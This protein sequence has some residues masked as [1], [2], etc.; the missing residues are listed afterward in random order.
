LDLNMGGLTP[1]ANVSTQGGAPTHLGFINNGTALGAA[2]FVGGS[3]FVVNLD[4]TGQFSPRS[5]LVTFQGSGPVLPN[6]QSSHAH[7]I[8]PF[9]DEVLVADLGSD[10]VWRLVQQGSSWTIKGSIDQAPGSGPR[11]L[12]VAN[13]SVF[14]IHEFGNTVTQHTIAP[15]SSGVAATPQVA[16][17]SILPLNLPANSKMGAAELLYASYPTPLLY[18]SNRNLTVDPTNIGDGDTITILSPSPALTPV[19][20]V[21]TGLAQ[22]RAMAFLG[23]NDEYLL[24]AGLLGGGVKVYERVSEEQGFLKLVASLNDTRILQPTSFVSVAQN[25]TLVSGVNNSTSAACRSA[26]K[27]LRRV[28]GK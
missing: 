2:N 14:I 1:L 27:R 7:Q 12:V 13:N 9:G 5:S 28:Y 24:A 21:K 4:T 20:F 3:A 8:V 6:Q 11:H 17:V 18:A 26:H 22:I 15:L 10:K 16:N 25:S 23:E 19:K